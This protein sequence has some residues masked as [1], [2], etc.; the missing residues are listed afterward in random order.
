M[1]EWDLYY[2]SLMA[3]TLHPG[4][5]KPGSNPPSPA[6]VA[7]LADEMLKEREKRWP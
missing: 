2:A 6:D 7:V 3:F 4:Y 5:L 1:S